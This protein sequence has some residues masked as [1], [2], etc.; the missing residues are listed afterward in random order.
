[1]VKITSAAW[2]IDN[3]HPAVRFFEQMLR[4]KAKFASGG[5]GSGGM[6]MGGSVLRV[7]CRAVVRGVIRRMMMRRTTERGEGAY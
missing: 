5:M 4:E 1:M 2:D 3:E 6:E 7:V